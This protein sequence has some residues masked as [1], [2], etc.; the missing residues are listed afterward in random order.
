ME[1]NGD[2]VGRSCEVAGTYLVEIKNKK[3]PFHLQEDVGYVRKKREYKKRKHKASTH[4][5]AHHSQ[6]HHHHQRESHR[7]SSVQ[8]PSYSEVDVLRPDMYSSDE[9]MS[10]VSKSILKSSVTR[11]LWKS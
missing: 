11:K 6:S 4:V 5:H 8:L 2:E 3:S 1:V 9:D 10:S 7:E